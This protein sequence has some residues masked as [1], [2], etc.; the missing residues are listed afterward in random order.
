MSRAVISN[1]IQAKIVDAY[2]RSVLH[3]K[4]PFLAGILVV[5]FIKELQEF[6]VQC[7]RRTNTAGELQVIHPR[8][9]TNIRT[10]PFSAGSLRLRPCCGQSK[11]QTKDCSSPVSMQ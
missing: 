4:H 9:G 10:S 2:D 1:I 7:Q 3:D 5:F 11:Y 6:R 8:I